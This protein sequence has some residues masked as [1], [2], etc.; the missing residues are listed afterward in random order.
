MSLADDFISVEAGLQAFKRDPLEHW[1]FAVPR[2]KQAF[3]MLVGEDPVEELLLRASNKGTKSETVAAYV[4]AC[5]QKR[6][7][8]DGVELP[9]WQGPVEGVQLVLDYKQQVLSVQGAYLRVLGSWPYKARYQ[10]AALDSLKIMPVG[11]N[12]DDERDWSF[13]HFLSQKNMQA[14]TGVRGDIVAFD[15]PPKMRVLRELRKAAHAGRRFVTIIGMT[16]TVRS[17]W[18]EIQVDYGDSPRRSLRR[19]DRD[20]AECRW[21]LDEVASWVLSD[22][23]KATLL[24]KWAH[25]PILDARQHGDYTS[26]EGKCPF[27]VDAIMQMIIEMTRDPQIV[28]WKVSRETSGGEP[29]SVIKVPVELWT[30]ARPGKTYYLD[31]DPSSG[32]DDGAHNPAEIQVTEMVSGELMARWNGYLSPYSVGVLAAGIGLQYHH[33]KIDIEMNDHWGVNVVRG[34]TSTRYAN[35]AFERRELRPGEWAKETGFKNDQKARALIIG[36]VQEWIDSWS[37][38]V[39]Y[40]NCPSRAVFDSILDTELD[41]RG[42]IVAIKGIDH[43]ES[44]V[45]RGQALRRC[46]RRR[47]Q[48]ANDRSRPWS[49]DDELEQLISGQVYDTGILKS[50]GNMPPTLPRYRPRPTL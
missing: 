15:E 24:R 18:A 21:S 43:G 17:Q 50:N 2:L 22:D 28:E 38:G 41:Y 7:H 11:G 13:I 14:G 47:M 42:K 5:L 4:V 8:L 23:E 16:P 20:R 34:V 31:V 26:S 3:A 33:A 49:P 35:L 45:C 39:K 25:D 36:S 40:G 30:P 6:K 19:V 12:P 32:I 46:V 27:N 9:Q 44:L 37:A 10:G 48:G 29:T 1:H